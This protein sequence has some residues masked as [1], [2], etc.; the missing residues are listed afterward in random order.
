MLDREVPLLGQQTWQIPKSSLSEMA[1]V[2][3]PQLLTPLSLSG[4]IRSPGLLGLAMAKSG[5][6]SQGRD[7]DVRVRRDAFAFALR[8]PSAKI[9]QMSS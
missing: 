2:L 4:Q 6:I 3:E 1:K 7:L 9:R 8:L 5:K